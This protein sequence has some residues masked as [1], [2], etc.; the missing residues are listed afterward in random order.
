MRFAW[1]QENSAD[2]VSVKRSVPNLL[3]HL[4]YNAAFWVFLPPFFTSMTYGT[5]FIAF[6]IVIVV[7]LVLNLYTNN[8]LNLTPEQFKNFPFRILG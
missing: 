4:A 1:L 2:T 6:T 7:R 8:V 3:T 5:G